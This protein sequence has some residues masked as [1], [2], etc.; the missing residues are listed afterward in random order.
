MYVRKRLALHRI[1]V[2]G[3]FAKHSIT[4]NKIWKASA[5]WNTSVAPRSLN[6]QAQR[7]KQ[8]HLA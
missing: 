5:K 8:N 3:I 2:S 7:R 4:F 6:I 1:Q